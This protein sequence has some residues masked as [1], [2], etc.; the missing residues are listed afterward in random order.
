MPVTSE[1]TLIYPVGSEP[2]LTIVK[3]SAAVHAGVRPAHGA[4][5]L[6]ILRRGVGFHYQSLR[7][8]RRALM[9]LEPVKWSVRCS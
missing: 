7:C 8:G 9:S 1:F 6:Q 4:A 3:R 5:G 2:T